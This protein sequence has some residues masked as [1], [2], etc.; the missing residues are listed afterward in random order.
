MEFEGEAS[1]LDRRA[2]LLLVDD[3]QE[4]LNT[5]SRCLSGA[6]YSVDAAESVSAAILSIE[7]NPPDLAILDVNMPDMNG[8][9]LGH[10]IRNEFGINFILLAGFADMDIVEQA[11]SAGT[12]GYLLKPAAT[13]QLV[14]SVEAA[15]GRSR[16]LKNLAD[17]ATNLSV[18]LEE[19]REISMAVG[20]LM[21]RERIGRDKAFELLRNTARQRRMKI[22]HVASELLQCSD[23][24]NIAA[25][26]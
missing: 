6:G 23:S 22:G 1:S 2:K 25:G 16:D 12:L 13:S 10:K 21:E 18:A 19:S 26:R 5:L 20:L 8:I 3:E 7:D 4:V 17:K 15:L 9:E 24:L 11:T 14:A